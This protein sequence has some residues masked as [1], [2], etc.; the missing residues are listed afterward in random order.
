M[1][2][3]LAQWLCSVPSSTGGTIYC[4]PAMDP[5]RG[6]TSSPYHHNTKKQHRLTSWLEHNSDFGPRYP[7]VSTRFRLVKRWTEYLDLARWSVSQA[8][9]I[10]TARM[11]PSVERR[12][13]C[14]RAAGR[15]CVRTASSAKVLLRKLHRA[16]GGVWI[17]TN[18]RK[19]SMI[20]SYP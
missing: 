4:H 17:H 3:H 5:G 13:K 9:R 6:S 15:R 20:I 1:S 8:F 2:S 12:Y 14:S 7:R 18:M 19:E 11:L 16:S 10:F